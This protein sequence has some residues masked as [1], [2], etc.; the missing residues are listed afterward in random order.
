MPTETWKSNP[1]E[2]SAF[3]TY[4]AWGFNKDLQA[5]LPELDVRV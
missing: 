4:A 5:G 2:A 1:Q 3:N